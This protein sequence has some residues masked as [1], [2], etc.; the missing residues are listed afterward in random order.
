[1][2]FST[3]SPPRCPDQSEFVG[4][5]EYTAVHAVN[6]R[7]NRHANGLGAGEIGGVLRVLWWVWG[8]NDEKCAGSGQE[9]EWL[10]ASCDWERIGLEGWFWVG[11]AVLWVCG[12]QC[13]QEYHVIEHATRDSA[14][15]APRNEQ[16]AVGQDRSWLDR[17]DEH[18]HTKPITVGQIPPGVHG[19]IRQL[20]RACRCVV[21]PVQ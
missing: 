13:T 9:S 2:P 12:W 10:W 14:H 16:Y 15:T 7:A 6:L 3:K 1:M 18:L 8:R 19:L 11:W 17:Q 21:K 5:F 4:T 20:R